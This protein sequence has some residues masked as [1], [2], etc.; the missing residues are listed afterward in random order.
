LVTSFFAEKHLFALTYGK[1]QEGRVP[2]P[3]LY[4]LSLESLNTAPCQHIFVVSAKKQ[5]PVSYFDC[6]FA[7]AQNGDK[8]AD[9]FLER[10]QYQYQNGF[11]NLISVFNPTVLISGGGLMDKY[12]SFVKNIIHAELN[13]PFCLTP[14]VK[15]IK[16]SS[17]G[18]SAL[19]GAATLLKL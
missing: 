4:H 18:L 9:T 11:W 2:L 6:L 13:N 12:F 7:A 16:A 5:F 14:N 10:L 1:Q 17:Q 8:K 15:V 3:F 19:C